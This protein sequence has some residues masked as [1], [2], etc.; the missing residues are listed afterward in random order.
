M[1]YVAFKLVFFG[2][3][4][5]VIFCDGVSACIPVLK[6]SNSKILF[7]CHFPDQLLIRKS[8]F[9]RN[10]YRKPW[11][12]LENVTTVMADKV[13]VNSGF[14]KNVYKR[15]FGDSHEPE[16]VYP[17]VNVKNVD[18]LIASSSLPI[19]KNKTVFLSLN[20]YDPSKKVEVAI[21]A[22]ALLCRDSPEK[23]GQ[24]Q[25]VIAGGYDPEVNQNVVYLQE[26]QNRAKS[27]NLSYSLL[28]SGQTI[29]SWKP[30]DI[31]FITD[32]S[33]VNKIQLMRS[34]L[35]LLYT[36]AGEHFGIVPVEAMVAEC[37]VIA[38]ASGGLLESVTTS[39]EVGLLCPQE[40]EEF[41][42]AMSR[43]VRTPSLAKTMGKNGRRRAIDHFSFET[44]SETL[45]YIVKE[46][47]QTKKRK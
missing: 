32:V 34:S 35:A 19:P 30:T 25:L 44:F 6:F 37:P 12:V 11:N 29:N 41:A 43:L 24:L 36:P 26:L 9:I 15:I 1:N 28:P 40:A 33:E 8:S 13:M 10:L 2:P 21:D 7:Y 31:V 47:T 39:E 27:H 45:D 20:R 17:C 46:V 22:F 14:T 5:D 3:A 38:V 42:K 4:F 16:I 18:K 23:L